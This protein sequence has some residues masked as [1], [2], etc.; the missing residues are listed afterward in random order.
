MGLTFLVHVADRDA[1]LLLETRPVWGGSFP[2]GSGDAGRSLSIDAILAFPQPML[3]QVAT[4]DLSPKN[5]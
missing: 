3:Q 2:P 4:V 1:R 5:R